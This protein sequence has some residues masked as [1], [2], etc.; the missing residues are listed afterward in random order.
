M[1]GKVLPVCIVAVSDKNDGS[2]VAVLLSEGWS[3][4]LPEEESVMLDIE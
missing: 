4:A 1:A 3:E 2:D